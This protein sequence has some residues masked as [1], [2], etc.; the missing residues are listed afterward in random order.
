MPPTCVEA[1]TTT[2]FMPIVE[3]W[4]AAATPVAVA[5]YTTTSAS[6]AG[7]GAAASMANDQAMLTNATISLRE[8]GAMPV[9][10]EEG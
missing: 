4:I 8:S 10:S 9:A 7:A 2:T 3:A 6:T 5:P 1:S